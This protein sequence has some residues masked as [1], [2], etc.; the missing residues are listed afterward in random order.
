M[1]SKLKYSNCF[2]TPICRKKLDLQLVAKSRQKS[3]IILSLTPRFLCRNSPN[4]T[5]CIA[6]LPSLLKHAFAWRYCNAFL[7]A[8]A[9]NESGQFRRLQKPRKLIGYHINVP[10]ATA[11]HVSLIISKYTGWPK[12]GTMFFVRLNFIKY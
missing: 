10:W 1:K 8:R 9:N 2:G 12:S 6:A 7:N 4:F 3:Y 11:K 5:R